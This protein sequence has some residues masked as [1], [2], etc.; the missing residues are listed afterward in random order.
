MTFVD[1]A[2]STQDMADSVD[3]VILLDHLCMHTHVD[4]IIN[5]IHSS[6]ATAAKPS[7]RLE[8]CNQD[9]SAATAAAVRGRWERCMRIQHGW[10]L[11]YALA[12]CCESARRLPRPSH[13]SCTA[14][15][16]HPSSAL[17]LESILE[18]AFFASTCVCPL[19]PLPRHRT[20]RIESS[21]TQCPGR[22]RIAAADHSTRP[23][24][25]SRPAPRTAAL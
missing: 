18:S 6:A 22:L 12:A 5:R 21:P 23:A 17:V 13:S 24:R 19:T 15:S 9:C 25:G 20:D 8:I 1:L 4:F 16:G 7:R 3:A 11:D 14:R 10:L 2:C